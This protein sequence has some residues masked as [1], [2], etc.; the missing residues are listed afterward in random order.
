MYN[1][2]LEVTPTVSPML[3][4][5]V[6]A[7]TLK[8]PRLHLAL[9]GVSCA[10]VDTSLLDGSWL[11]T[12]SRLIANRLMSLSDSLRT[13]S[14]ENTASNSYSYIATSETA[15]TETYLSSCYQIITLFFNNR[16]TVLLK[17]LQRRLNME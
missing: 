4:L 10:S 8:L 1:S 13:D 7:Q 11:P 16:V 14:I 9:L 2:S 5:Q 3:T 12:N 6:T 15:A 17:R